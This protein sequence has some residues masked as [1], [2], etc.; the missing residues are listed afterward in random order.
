MALKWCNG[1]D[2]YSG[3][4]QEAVVICRSPCYLL[5]GYPRGDP[6]TS[7]FTYLGSWPLAERD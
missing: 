6:E 5:T 4:L 3:E 1:I 7:T 2:D